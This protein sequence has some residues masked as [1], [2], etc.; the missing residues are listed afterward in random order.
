MSFVAAVSL[1]SLGEAN[2]EYCSNKHATQ[3]PVILE[4][5]VIEKVQA[6]LWVQKVGITFQASAIPSIFKL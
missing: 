5:S 6:T 1:L 3:R 4:G 2:I